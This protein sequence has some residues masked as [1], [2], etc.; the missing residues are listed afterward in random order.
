MVSVRIPT[1]RLKKLLIGRI[2][3]NIF[4]NELLS[5]RD[6]DYST[7]TSIEQMSTLKTVSTCWDTV[8]IKWPI[9]R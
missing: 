5:A 7:G 6:I 2:A 4:L 9:L 1:S 8:L 3:G